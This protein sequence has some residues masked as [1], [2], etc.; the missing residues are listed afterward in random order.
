MEQNS[1][2]VRALT[3]NEVNQV[4]MSWREEFASW[5]ARQG[6]S[7][8][9]I[10]A[11]VCDL[12]VWCGWFEAATGYAFSP[13]LLNSFD[14]ARFRQWQLEVEGV[15]PA[16]WNRRLAS[17][18]VLAD[19][20][21]TKTDVRLAED[22]FEG[23]RP[24]EEV[25]LPAD[26]LNDM[27]FGRLGRWVEGT[28]DEGNTEARRRWTQRTRALTG[29]M[30]YAGLREAEAASLTMLD[31]ELGERKGKLVVKAGKGDKRREVPINA[32]LRRVLRRWLEVRRGGE[33]FLFPNDE[34]GRLSERAIQDAM[35]E[36]EKRC[37]V[38]DLRAHRLRHTFCKRMAD[39]G[40]SLQ[41]I[42]QA[43]GHSSLEVTRRYVQP[44][45]DDLEEAVNQVGLGKM[46]RK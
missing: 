12:N 26:W 40:V 37:G 20:I 13:E 29:V 18:R 30:L 3:R 7:T 25:A 31:V 2:S 36:V 1:S 15:K 45:W 24:A 8:N 5:D 43:A 19:W 27:E 17:L 6:K 35:K 32:E 38:A 42:A 4:E 16:T 9:T 10:E 14:L 21:R 41:Q 39:A 28:H 44:G 23:I 11:H 33:G 46:A 34:G 22:L